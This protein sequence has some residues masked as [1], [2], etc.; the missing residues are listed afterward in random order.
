[1]Q[2][3]LDSYCVRI[4][5]KTRRCRVQLYVTKMQ[6]RVT[7]GVDTTHLMRRL[8]ASIAKRCSGALLNEAARG[9]GGKE[10]VFDLNKTKQNK[11]ETP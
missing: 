4:R 5:A 8:S 11:R 10:L 6:D 3:K 7:Y 2:L 1:M 9:M